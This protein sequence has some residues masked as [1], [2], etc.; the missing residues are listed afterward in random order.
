MALSQ[1]LIVVCPDSTDVSALNL[2]FLWKLTPPILYI[3][4][5]Y[6][7][8]SFYVSPTSHTHIHMPLRTHVAFES[9]FQVES[10]VVQ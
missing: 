7:I 8:I 3:N 9:H 4:R 6:D 1:V 10:L 2:V 5:F